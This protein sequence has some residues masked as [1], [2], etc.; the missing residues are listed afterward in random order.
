MQYI[1]S[2]CIKLGKVKKIVFQELLLVFQLEHTKKWCALFR[3]RVITHKI[4]DI[5]KKV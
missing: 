1:S 5:F 4:P 2:N 3:K